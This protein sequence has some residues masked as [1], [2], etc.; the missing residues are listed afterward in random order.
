M[1]IPST[2]LNAFK[3]LYLFQSGGAP[4]N[5]T[6]ERSVHELF[7]GA[8]RNKSLMCAKFMNF[9]FWPF[10]WFGLPG[11]L[12]IQAPTFSPPP[13]DRRPSKNT[14]NGF[15]DP[16]PETQVVNFN[17][18]PRPKYLPLSRDRCSNT[19]V[20]LCFCGIAAYRCCTPTSFR[21]SGLSQSKRGLARGYRRRS[22]PL[23]PIAL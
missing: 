5:Q 20:A 6:K 23:K 3:G 8:F 4:A 7:A 2:C 9:S 18:V 15:E 16:S 11:R 21:K 17:L 14:V 10:L 13:F 12:L 1:H 22:L 19:P